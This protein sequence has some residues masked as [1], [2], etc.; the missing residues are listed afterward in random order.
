MATG[1]QAGRI[2]SIQVGASTAALAEIGEIRNWSFNPTHRPIDATSNDSSGWDEF[3]LGQR[4]FTLEAESLML[5]TEAEQITVRKAFST[6]GVKTWMVRPSTS[7]T[8]KYVFT[9]WVRDW[10]NSANHDNA[11]LQNFSVQGTGAFT[12]ST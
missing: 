7:Q 12:Y 9:G 6:T 4:S 10:R 3:I 8:Q 1:A 2:A 11:V 5:R